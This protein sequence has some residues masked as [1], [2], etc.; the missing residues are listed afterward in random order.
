ML[1]T[2]AWIETKPGWRLMK[3]SR[4]Y[5]GTYLKRISLGK[6]ICF[7]FSVFNVKKFSGGGL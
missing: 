3:K 2:S 5:T 6:Q 1:D 4:G 7:K